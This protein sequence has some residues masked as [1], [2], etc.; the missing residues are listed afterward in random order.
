MNI[1]GDRHGAKFMC[2]V[3]KARCGKEREVKRMLETEAQSAKCTL[4][5]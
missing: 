3:H 5:I 1:K 2:A 4:F